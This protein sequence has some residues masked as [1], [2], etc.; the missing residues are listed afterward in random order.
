MNFFRKIT[1]WTEEHDPLFKLAK[2]GAYSVA[3]QDSDN[4]EGIGRK[5]GWDWLTQEAQRNQQNPGRAI[6]KAAATAASI[7]AG[8]LLGG[9]AGGAA[10]TAGD[11]VGT[12]VAGAGPVTS[13]TAYEASLQAAKTLA[14]QQAAQQAATEAAMKGLLGYQGELA[15]VGEAN[16]AGGLLGGSSP[17]S[18]GIA[19]NTAFDAVKNANGFGDAMGNLGR[20]ATDGAKSPAGMSG[21]DAMTGLQGLQM[22]QSP[23]E[24]RP[25]APPPR[26][27]APAQAPS[28]GGYQMS[29]IG[30]S[31]DPFAGM[32]E[33]DKRK[34][35]AMMQQ[36]GGMR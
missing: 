34:L 4:M 18:A 26:P 27:S 5:L 7:Y 17:T 21:K 2:K 16:A 8:G 13:G 25:M 3:K 10:T 29:P 1:D 19:H 32:S 36:Q 31:S 12:G 15:S 20:W 22:M 33:E 6:G 24:Q 30:S 11:A 14:E 35:L 28:F 23:Q 9:G